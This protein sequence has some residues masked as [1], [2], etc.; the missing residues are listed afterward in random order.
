MRKVPASLSNYFKQRLLKWLD[1]RVPASPEHHLNLN[2]IFIL[3]SGFGWSF[4]ILSLCLFLLGTN[5]QNNLMLLLSYLCLSIMLLTLFY[6][7]KNFARLALKA[8]PPDSFHCNLDGEIHLQIIPHKNT[9]TKPCSGVLSVKWL[10]VVRTANTHTQKTTD[11]DT[12][13]FLERNF[14]FALNTH[15]GS[16]KGQRQSLRVP[17]QIPKRGL[18]TLG[19]M[20]IAC[21]FPLGLYKCWT[22]LDFDQQVIVYAKPQE[23]P[24]TIN[25]IANTDE[26]KN[27]SELSHPT[28]SEDFYALKD[29]EVGQPLNRVSWKHV[30][31]NGNWVSKSFTSLQSDSYILSIPSNTDLETAVSALT[32][33]VLSL[34]K[35][36]SWTK[37]EFGSSA[38]R[39]FGVQFKGLNIAPDHGAEHIHECL[40]ALACLAS[41]SNTSH[42]TSSFTSTT[43]RPVSLA[44]KQK[45]KMRPLK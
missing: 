28:S 11:G 14:S 16:N 40:S 21:D 33:A 23:G 10:N 15:L 26:S 13:A 34:T 2:S 17:L 9:P 41:A 30:A 12:S 37:A 29:Y 44:S 1:K 32:H 19:R 20:T 6:T 36:G 25:R 18:F 39:G 42:N 27:V 38:K 5:Y 4:I 24:I 45:K 35:A 3:P 8:L 31:K 22:H 43:N 7:H